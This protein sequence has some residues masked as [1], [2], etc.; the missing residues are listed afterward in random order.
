MTDTAS[1][2]FPAKIVEIISEDRVAF[3]RGSNEGV[4]KGQR[5]LVYALGK[6]LLDPETGESLGQLEIVRGT[7]AA[8]HVQDRLTTI[9]SDARSPSVRRVIRR[10][11][12]YA[13]FSGRT[14]ETIEES[15]QTTGF[16]SP[17]VGDFVKPL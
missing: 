1:S 2:R 8:V 9:E 11:D 7:G 3:N 5:F 16:D 15:G 14:E 12:P 4:K 13:M 6:E 17:Q 10:T